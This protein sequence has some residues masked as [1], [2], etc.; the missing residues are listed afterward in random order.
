VRKI[1]TLGY[2]E[3]LAFP[4]HPHMLRHAAGYKLANRGHDSRAI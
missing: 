3:G 1:V 4:V 2:Q